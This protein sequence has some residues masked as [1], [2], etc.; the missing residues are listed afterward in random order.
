MYKQPHYSK[1]IILYIR[2]TSG[3]HQQYIENTSGILFRAPS[4]RSSITPDKSCNYSSLR[5]PGGKISS[6]HRVYD[7]ET[8]KRGFNKFFNHQMDQQMDDIDD[9]G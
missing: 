7:K 3:I 6:S 9:T 5:N 1:S 2:N 8:R 4:S